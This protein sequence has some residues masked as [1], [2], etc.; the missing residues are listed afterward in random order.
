MRSASED[1]K[2][3]E[4]EFSESPESPEKKPKQSSAK[5][6]LKSTSNKINP[7]QSKKEMRQK[8]IKAFLDENSD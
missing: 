6:Q 7:K 5:P 1:N 8:S 2:K 4:L 3:R